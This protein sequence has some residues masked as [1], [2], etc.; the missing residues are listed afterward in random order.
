MHREVRRGLR[1]STVSNQTTDKETTGMI[2]ARLALRAAGLLTPVV[3]IRG[4]ADPPSRRTR[5]QVG[6][7]DSRLRDNLV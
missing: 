2:S 4:R 7:R 3:D 6:Y 5:L 1:P